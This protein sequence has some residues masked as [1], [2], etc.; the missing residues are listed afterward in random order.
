M[1]PPKHLRSGKICVDTI[2]VLSALG[3]IQQLSL[4]G[5][6][7]HDPALRSVRQ[8]NLFINSIA[9]SE[10]FC[11]MFDIWDNLE[12]NISATRPDSRGRWPKGRG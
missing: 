7:G 12:Y 1:T 2:R 8:I 11:K 3:A 4:P 10:R 9:F 6:R 5:R